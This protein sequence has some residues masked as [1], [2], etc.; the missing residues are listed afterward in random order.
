[1][2]TENE[3]LVPIVRDINTLLSLDTYQ[4]MSD[5]EIEVVINYKIDRAIARYDINRNKTAIE[6]SSQAIK[7]YYTT[8][9]QNSN[10]VLQ[11][12][13]NVSIPWVTVAQ[14]GTVSQNV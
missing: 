1:M 10:T 7:E 6:E 12:M 14:D 5:D 9:V 2:P 8:A 3:S 13:L 4:D 11:S